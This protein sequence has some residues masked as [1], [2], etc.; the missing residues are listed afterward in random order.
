M[1]TPQDRA[2]AAIDTLLR[3]PFT[4]REF[5]AATGALPGIAATSTKQSNKDKLYGTASNLSDSL[6]AAELAQASKLTGAARDEAVLSATEKYRQ[7]LLET[8]GVDA[9]KQALL[10]LAQQADGEE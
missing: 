9:S 6:Y 1:I 3:G 10:R 5:N 8:L 2:M 7:Q 4:L